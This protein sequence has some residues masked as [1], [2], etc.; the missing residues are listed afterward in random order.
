MTDSKSSQHA[1]KHDGK[2]HSDSFKHH[3]KGGRKGGKRFDR[4]DGKNSSFKNQNIEEEL[5]ESKYVAA[6]EAAAADSAAHRDEPPRTFAELGVPHELVDALERDGKTTAFPIQADTLPDSLAGRDILG[7]GQTGSGKTL[8]F[9]IPLIAR[10]AQ[11]SDADDA[12]R[13]FNAIKNSSDK[14]ARKKAMLPHPRALVLAP[15]RELVNQIDEVIRPLAEVYGIRTV[16]IY[17]GVRQGRQ[18][19]GLR[20]GAQIVVACPGRLEDLL[21]QKLLSLESVRVAVLD[22]ADEMADMGFLPSVEKLLAQVAP[23]GQ[24]MLFSATLDHG[25]DK[26][27]DEFLHEPKVHAVDAADAQVDTLTQHVFK[28]T[29]D[30]KPEVI[31][32]LASG[33]DKRIIFTRTKYQAKELAEKLVKHGI[34]AVD[35]QGNLSQKQRDHHLA[36]FERG[37]VRVLVAT[38]VAARGIDV[39]DVALVIQT[40][41]PADPK[42]FLHR[43]GRTARAGEHGDVVTLVLPNQ[44]RSSHR[45]FHNAGIDAKPVAV[46]PES[47]ELLEL[48]GEVAPVVEGWSLGQVDF[49]DKHG[50]NGKKKDGGK[51]KG[52]HDRDD[53]DRRDRKNR[54]DKGGAHGKGH[55]PYGHKG[56]DVRETF[57]GFNQPGSVDFTATE[58]YRNAKHHGHKDAGQRKHGKNRFDR[59][60]GRRDYDM[61]DSGRSADR[62]FDRSFRDDEMPQRHSG[63]RI[64]SYDEGPRNRKQRREREFGERSG[65]WRHGGKKHRDD[66]RFVSAKHE[67]K[68]KA[69]KKSKP[70]GKHKTGHKHTGGK[71]HR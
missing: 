39:S 36:A 6:A 13:D 21:N 47:P 37:F 38:D 46:T 29:K 44:R 63:R 1:H 14:D 23:D 5:H 27:V 20:R 7:R 32:V 65:G 54:H 22:E 57:D 55:A 4:R 48:V 31:R 52:R 11:S 30:D 8:A 43:S 56:D 58:D 24:R 25:V 42:S 70:A 18:V 40:E 67:K 34:P 17:G 35:L 9:S 53:K 71:K 51:R 2:R 69:S 61:R 10:L 41:P 68:S 62:D 50:K 60:T 45:L 64:S 49:G 15:T 66:V 12:I 19:D 26:L 28:V 3:G 59:G 16:T 33:K